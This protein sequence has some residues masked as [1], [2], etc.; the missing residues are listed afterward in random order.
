MT[1]PSRP[2]RRRPHLAAVAVVLALVG[3]LTG[4]GLRME[5]PPPSPRT[6]DA[7]EVA[8]ERAVTDSVDL[9]AA[10][11][12]PGADP[13]KPVNKI[14]AT[15]VAAAHAH[16]DQLGGPYVAGTP[17]PTGSP[18]PS[19]GPSAAPTSTASAAPASGVVVVA[20]LVLGATHAREDAE[21]VPDGGL[22]RLLASV[23]AA[24][25]LQARQLAAADKLVPPSLSHATMPD[26][27]PAGVEPSALSALVA[28]EDEAGYGYEVIAAK[29]SGP[30]RTSALDRAGEHRTRAEAWARLGTIAETHR[31]PRRAA[32]ALPKGLDD[33]AAAKALAKSMAQ[34]L[35]VSYAAL[36]ADAEP[37][38]RAELI[39]SLVAMSAEAIDWGAPVPVFP[40]LPER[41]AR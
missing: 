3:L 6:V 9:E 25:L 26:A 19:T 32:Y 5:T 17:S 4:C 31:D 29:L 21:T 7:N 33:P 1:S 36:V 20:R 39:S 34:A 30:E 37:G 27:L 18:T 41:A 24:R 8:R 2:A 16:V 28:G 13:G 35:A 12:T 23:S 10:A 38:S 22:A 40:G 11:A 15:I 14:R